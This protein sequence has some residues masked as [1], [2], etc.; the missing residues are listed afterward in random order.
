MN[1][2]KKKLIAMAG[3][4]EGRLSNG[5]LRS[6]IRGCK[7]TEE[8]NLN[9]QG[10]DAQIRYL[11]ETLPR[12]NIAEL[13][14]KK[15]CNGDLCSLSGPRDVYRRCGCNC[16]SCRAIDGVLDEEPTEKENE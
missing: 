14:E 4:Q 2:N 6:L 5:L 7:L 3:L 11:L 13:K 8:A 15:H 10:E 9:K 12:L 16:P 1:E